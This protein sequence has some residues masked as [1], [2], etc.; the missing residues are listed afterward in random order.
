MRQALKRL[1]KAARSV[2]TSDADNY[3]RVRVVYLGSP[4]RDALDLTP[5]GFG[6][7][8]PQGSLAVVLDLSAQDS[9]PVA[10]VADPRN[11]LYRNSVEGEAWL[12]NPG[13]AA[14]VLLKAGGDIEVTAPQGNVNITA[15]TSTTVTIGTMTA[16][17]DKDGLT[18][19]DGDVVADGISLKTHTH[20]GVTA[21][22]DN[23]GEPNT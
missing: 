12:E 14:L 19:T 18:V 3:R 9:N 8:A 6:H 20:S 4:E 10:I 17:F 1:I 7:H 5:Y 15:Q 21:G 13:T 22:G 11:R 23:T 2:M 16:V